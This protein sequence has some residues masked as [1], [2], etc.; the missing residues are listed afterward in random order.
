LANHAEC[1]TN[2]HGVNAFLSIQYPGVCALG[3]VLARE[4]LPFKRS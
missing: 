2:E 3:S 1:P 4:E